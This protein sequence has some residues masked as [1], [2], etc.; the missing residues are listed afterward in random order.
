M[1]S[2]S[3]FSKI[4][5]NNPLWRHWNDGSEDIKLVSG[6]IVYFR[7]VKFDIC[8]WLFVYVYVCVYIS[9]CMYKHVRT[10]ISIWY[11]RPYWNIYLS[12]LKQS[13][14]YTCHDISD[15]HDI[16]D[17]YPPVHPCDTH[18]SKVCFASFRWS[19]WSLAGTSRRCKLHC[20]CFFTCP[21]LWFAAKWC[22]WMFCR[23]EKSRLLRV[24]SASGS[25]EVPFS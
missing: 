12:V 24:V 4:N 8:I 10:H 9:I 22:G 23:G 11:K 14:T 3:I 5:S 18:I 13:E 20:L 17:I 19:G 2:N 21:C 15:M 1:S 6:W 7:F 25:T 16:H